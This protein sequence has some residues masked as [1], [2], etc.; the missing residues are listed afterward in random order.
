MPPDFRHRQ[1][2][3]GGSSLHVVE[4]GDPGAEPF[5]FLHGWPQSWSAWSAVMSLAAEHVRAIAI[6]LPGVG[7]STGDATDGTKRQLATRVH[8]L[9]D[10]LDLDD[11]TLVG[12]DV[13]GTIV[14]SYLREFPGVRR[15]VLLDVAMPGVDPWDAM[16]RNPYLFH[17]ALH[18]IPELP[19]QLVQGRERVY[20]DF[21]FD[22][23][24]GDPSAISSAARDEYAAAY[25]APGALTA[26]FNWY[27]A[28]GRD[29]PDAQRHIAVATPVLYLRGEKG[30]RKI[31]EFAGGFSQT[32]LSDLAHDL[33][34]GAGHFAHEEAP[35]A[36]WQRIAAFAGL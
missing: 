3:V 10:A 34:P 22:V 27:R 6:D 14:Y 5:L 19:E 26:G 11:L 17:I 21:F 2:T 4:A 15:A 35:D 28:F 32:G 24:S 20:F 30:R 12:Q 36:V 7:S 25:A 33:I 18:S 31:A 23:L 13:G 8:D 29:A 1:V 9:V 16:L